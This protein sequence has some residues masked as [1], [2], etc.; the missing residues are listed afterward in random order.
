[1][2][3]AIF[4]SGL[5]CNKKAKY[6]ILKNEGVVVLAGASQC[7]GDTY[8]LKVMKKSPVLINARESLLSCKILNIYVK[9][10]MYFTIMHLYIII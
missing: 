7:T 9:T 8:L 5:Y 1:M 4:I 2:P 3:F 6:R 10:I